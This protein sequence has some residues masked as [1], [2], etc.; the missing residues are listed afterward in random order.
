MS[1]S[2]SSL[3]Q[4]VSVLNW[5]LPATLVLLAIIYQLAAAQWASNSSS[6]SQTLGAYIL[7]HILI[8]PLL[9]FSAFRL[10]THWLD[11]DERSKTQNQ[12]R[13]HQLASIIDTAA[14]AIL[15][16]DADGKIVCWNLGAERLFGYAAQE[17]T[18][19]SLSVLLGEGAAVEVETRWLA[20]M[21]RREGHVDKHETT[22]RDVLGHR[23]EV[24]LTLTRLT[25]ERGQSA[26]MSVVLRDITNRKRHE[27]ENQ[28]LNTRL[29]AQAAERSR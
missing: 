18:G 17:I 8:G 4:N 21:V 7:L 10:I 27:E 12:D 1:T 29:N 26:G 24:E 28:L 22:C 9:V 25:D 19:H 3:R 11:E 20:D 2:D 23:I 13:E 15:S 5:A 14:D 6:V 16:T